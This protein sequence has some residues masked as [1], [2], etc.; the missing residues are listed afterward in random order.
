[1]TG[2]LSATRQGTRCPATAPGA[3]ATGASCPKPQCR[4]MALSWLNLPC[5]LTAAFIKK[6]GPP[7]PRHAAAWD[8]RERGLG[9]PTA[10]RR[11]TLRG[12]NHK[13]GTRRALAIVA[14][15]FARRL[16]PGNR[17]C[18]FELNFYLPR[19]SNPQSPRFQRGLWEFLRRSKPLGV[20]FRGDE[21]ATPSAAKDAGQTA[22]K[23]FGASQARTTMRPPDAGSSGWASTTDARP[24]IGT[25]SV[26][27]SPAPFDTRPRTG[28]S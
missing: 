1:M 17:F 8:A 20:R 13:S 18:T 4:L 24:R 15:G 23:E 6:S 5:A 14:A 19:R 10:S 2:E 12:S 3:L 21:F 27:L 25:A 11:A 7:R 16:V 26:A 28:A 22:L 9:N